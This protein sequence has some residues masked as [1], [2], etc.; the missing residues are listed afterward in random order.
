MTKK[1]SFLTHLSLYYIN[2]PTTT[3][4]PTKNLKSVE[5]VKAV[6]H[7]TFLISLKRTLDPTTTQH[8]SFSYTCKIV[9]EKD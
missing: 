5:N 6:S 1:V 3:T 7:L 8:T 9:L 4:T 2:R